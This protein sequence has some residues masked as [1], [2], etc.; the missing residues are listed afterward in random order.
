MLTLMPSAVSAS[1]AGMPSEVAGT[2]IMT[3]GRATLPPEMPSLGDGC[4]GIVGDAWRDFEAHEA[5]RAVAV[6]VHRSEDISRQ[7]DVLDDQPFGERPIA[8][9]RS[10]SSARRSPAS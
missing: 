3:L 6:V 10:A 7:L 4:V 1:T 2:L 9:L 5:V 8:D